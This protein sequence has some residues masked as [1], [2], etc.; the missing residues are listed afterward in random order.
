MST[1]KRTSKKILLCLMLMAAGNVLAVDGAANTT[2][3]EVE[4]SRAEKMMFVDEHLRNIDKPE[5]LKYEF[6][7]T[8]SLEDGFK[9]RIILKITR[10]QDDGSRAAEVDFFTG[11]HHIPVEPRNSAFLNPV[12]LLYLQG[13]TLEMKRLTDG[14]FRYFQSRMK[15][16]FANTADI[17]PV[18]FEFAGR[19]V[20]G[21]S[22]TITPYVNDPHRKEFEDYADKQYEFLLSDDIPG[23][24][25]SIRAIIPDMSKKDK[26]MDEPLSDERLTLVAVQAN[27]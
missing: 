17:K 8:G 1:M 6:V 16:A 24:L 21:Y 5:T 11:E 7:K 20:K 3:Q 15:F 27:S 2:S 25:Y 22:I 18:S 12:L 14:G 19:E 13:D 23:K 4:F 9:D 26:A 10:L